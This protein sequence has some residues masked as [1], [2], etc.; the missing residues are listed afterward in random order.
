[1][2]KLIEWIFEPENLSCIQAEEWK[3]LQMS[4]QNMSASSTLAFAVNSKLL[5]PK[6]PFYFALGYKNNRLVIAIP[7]VIKKKRYAGLSYNCLQVINHDHLDLFTAVGQEY[8]DTNAMLS[9]LLL[10]CR[11][12]LSNWHMFYATRW[13]FYQ[14]PARELACPVYSKV[15][16]YFNLTEISN[17]SELVPKKLLKNIIRFEKKIKAEKTNLKLICSKNNSELKRSLEYFFELEMQGWK[18]R[19]K[20]AI[21]CQAD[22]KLFY[23]NCWEDFSSSSNS[24]IFLLYNSDLLIAAAI[25]FQSPSSLYLHKITFNETLARSGPGSILIKKIIEYAIAEPKLKH[26][27]FNTF[28]KWVERW[29]PKQQSLNAVQA[30]NHDLKGF[31]LKLIFTLFNRLKMLKRYIKDC[32]NAK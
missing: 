5:A 25:G 12:K 19:K 10:A 31:V 29:H 8:V 15:S 13:H 24:R 32:N 3:N 26:I 20:S 11:I 28:P 14:P 18:G 9:S 1:M 6:E 27:N 23:Q 30:F 17:I 16:A 2:N 21:A 7:L 22:T 4:C